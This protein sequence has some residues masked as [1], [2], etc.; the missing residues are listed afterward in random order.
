MQPFKTTQKCW[1]VPLKS[2][3]VQP[4]E[5]ETSARWC[6]IN[7]SVTNSQDFLLVTNVFSVL[8]FSLSIRYKQCKNF[9]WNIHG[10][11]GG[12]W[13]RSRIASKG[14]DRLNMATVC[15]FSMCHFVPFVFRRNRKYI[16]QHLLKRNSPD[17]GPISHRYLWI[18]AMIITKKGNGE[19][20]I[21]AIKRV[22]T[23]DYAQFSAS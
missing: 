6:F 5:S 7:K 23:F 14:R 4:R 3:P 22:Q 16:S 20:S 19:I 2:P 17:I 18:P 11:G 13:V 15:A 10:G 12:G 1:I 9:G 21:K 8:L